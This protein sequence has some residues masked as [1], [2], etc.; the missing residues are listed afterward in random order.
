MIKKKCIANAIDTSNVT[1]DANRKCINAGRSNMS[2]NID[3]GLICVNTDYKKG[4]FRA[5]WSCRS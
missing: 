4:A 3:I 5:L 2:V 1:I